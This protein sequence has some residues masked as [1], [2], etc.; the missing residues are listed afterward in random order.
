MWGLT[1]LLYGIGLSTVIELMQSVG[2]RGLFE[3]DDIFDNGI[4][5]LVGVIVFFW[6]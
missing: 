4:G 6:W 5:T 2:N 1:T 3:F